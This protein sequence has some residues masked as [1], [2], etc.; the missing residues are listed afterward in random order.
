MATSLLRLGRLGSLKCL[1][2]ES[3]G[4]L[5][6]QF[7]AAFCTK[8]AEPKKP[9]K[10]AKASIVE[11]P[12][13]RAALLAYKT[14][15]AFPTRLSAP[16][17]ISQ[18]VALGAT[19]PESADRG[20]GGAEAETSR[21]S[22]AA[23]SPV[24]ETS[25]S[26]DEESSSSSSSSDSESDSDSDSDDENPDEPKKT[27]DKTK[28]R[29]DKT[30]TVVEPGAKKDDVSS[31]A[32][33]NNLTVGSDPVKKPELPP[34]I[35][36]DDVAASKDVSA[37]S[38]DTQ[39]V[40]DP[41]PTLSTSSAEEIAHEKQAEAQ[42][43]SVTEV[44]GSDPAKK[45]E[46]PPKTAKDDVA[47]SKDV[48]APSSDTQEVVDPAPTLSTSSAEEIAHEKQAGAQPESE[49]LLDQASSEAVPQAKDSAA[50]I[51]ETGATD[52]PKN[53]PDFAKEE[54]PEVRTEEQRNVSGAEELVD[55]AP[56]ISDAA[57]ASTESGVAAAHQEAAPA[58]VA[59]APAPAPEPFDNSSYQNLQHHSYHT[60][61]YVDMDVEM[62]KHRLPQPSTG[63][64]SPRD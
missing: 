44:P 58:P 45:P 10:K 42:P 5:R 38:A 50:E 9:A 37:P 61:T 11:A 18:G 43:E 57:E 39:E 51:P 49:V 48:S 8:V 1:Q 56:V 54:E 28:H 4:A 36:K 47:A 31:R 33:K 27:E 35:A 6:T 23:A 15:V 55:A 53:V 25:Q 24:K 46:L 22:E 30:E 60:Y 12:E 59:A 62:A 26:K 3:W 34:K 7:T 14:P 20:S 32:E 52:T 64:A 2:Q 29:I 21:S 63:R 41:A 13:E 19:S 16:G 17:L 40:V